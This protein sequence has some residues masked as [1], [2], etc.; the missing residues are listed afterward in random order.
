[1][2]R[3]TDI[4]VLF[5]AHLRTLVGVE[6]MS[7][8][9]QEGLSVGALI[10]QLQHDLPALRAALQTGKVVVAVNQ[11]MASET[12]RLHHG[13]EVALLPPFSGGTVSALAD[14]VRIQIEAFDIASE[15]QKIQ[16]TSRRIGAVVTFL[17]TARDFSQGRD[18][19]RIAFEHYPKMAEERLAEIRTQALKEHD[20]IEVTLIHR[21]GEIPIGDH[22]V[23][24][25]VGAQHRSE[26]FQ[27]CAWCIDTLKKTTPIWKK[28]TTS[29]GEI[30]V[31][32]P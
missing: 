20:I 1:M 18:V 27:A 2:S 31:E 12:E 13:D 28:E 24:V 21:V 8:P 32:H 30:W 3:P 29:N 23:F 15:I 7:I 11:K 25:A 16:G 10:A 22:I 26:A 9:V 6:E 14:H 5:F 17:G 4:R 19:S